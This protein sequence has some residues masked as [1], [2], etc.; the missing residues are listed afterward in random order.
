MKIKR[1]IK[2]YFIRLFRLKG[3]PHQVAAGL[4]MGF[5]PSWFPTFGLGPVLSV[6]L[7]KLTRS[8]EVAAL[9][10]GVIGTPIWPLLF[11]FN[12]KIGSLLLDRQPKVDGLEEVDYINALQHTIEGVTGSHSRGFSFLIGAIT[13]IFVFSILIY[14]VAYLIFKKYRVSILEKIR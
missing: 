7:A 6:S 13:N 2:Y 14:L 1:R 10:G 9:V 3:S 11:L 8:N 4:T 5:L 12:Y